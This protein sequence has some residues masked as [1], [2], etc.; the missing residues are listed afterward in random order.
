MLRTKS[1][2]P[3]GAS[4]SSP[5]FSTKLLDN[6]I[7]IPLDGLISPSIPSE[8]DGRNKKR[9]MENDE[10]DGRPSA[11]GPRLEGQFSRYGGNER[12]D[13][14]PAGGWGGRVE[15]PQ[16]HGYRDGGMDVYG[17]VMGNMGGMGGMGNMGGIGG[18]NGM[19]HMNGRRQQ[20][21]QPPDQKRGI[22]RDYH[23]KLFTT[24]N[25]RQFFFILPS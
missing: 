17:T 16:N 21:Y 3:Y 4:T 1:Y 22:C 18:M 9:S 23:S 8:P 10:R 19:S 13:G 20:A 11:K 25:L 15:R 2:L 7:P 5:T 12:L 14:R 24:D 6:G